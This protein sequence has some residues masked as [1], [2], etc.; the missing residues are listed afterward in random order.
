MIPI[1][2]TYGNDKQKQC[3][4]AWANNH[5]TEIIYGGSKGSAKSY[6]GAVCIFGNAFMYPN[7]HYFIARKK[8]TDLRKFTIP[9]IHEVFEHLKIHDKYYNFNGNDNYFELH[10]KSKVYLLDAKYLPSDPQYARFGSMQMTGGWIEEAGEFENE[11]KIN[12]QASIGRWKNDVY[13]IKGKLLQTCNPSKNY[14]YKDYKKNKEGKLEDYKKFIQA[15]P[16]DNKKLPKGYIENLEKILTPNA[17][18]RLL[19]GNWEFD[20]NP[21]ALINYAN[22]SNLFTNDFVD[23]GIKYI[24][25]DVAR[26]GRDKTVIGVWSGYR[27]ERIVIMEKYNT[28]EVSNKINQLRLEYSVASSNIV[29]DEDGVGGGCVDTI[30]GSR[31]FV[32]N[33]S[34]LKE[35]GITQ[36]YK[37]LKSQ[38]YFKLADMINA[39]KIYV[40]CD[41]DIKEQL[42]KEIEYVQQEQWDG[43]GKKAIK[44]KDWVKEKLGHSPDISDML[45]MRMYFE[46]LPAIF[47]GHRLAK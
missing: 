23:N 25:T 17:K 1:I 11:C 6:T 10:N 14:L 9:T 8:L 35:K 28:V 41:D 27:L 29:I 40:R 18:E 46:L 7:T 5:T 26:Y 42:T 31:G 12:L 44:S 39:N 3:I 22:I 2:N 38:C 4:E 45:M 36:N 47:T 19:Y 34:P 24:S 21:D 30:K 43:E 15:Y 13:N 20:D 33:L 37:N 16:N 32:N